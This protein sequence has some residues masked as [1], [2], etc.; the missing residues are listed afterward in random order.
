[1]HNGKILCDGNTHQEVMQYMNK[2]YKSLQDFIVP[3]VVKEKS[4]LMFYRV[5]L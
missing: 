5:G 3:L 4:P 2:K 1:M